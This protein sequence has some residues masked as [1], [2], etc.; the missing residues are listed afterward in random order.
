M[1]RSERI[2]SV[3]EENGHRIARVATASAAGLLGG[4][5]SI[6]MHGHAQDVRGRL[7][8]SRANRT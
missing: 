5:G 4:P 7:P 1:G 3:D 6:G 2:T 8:T